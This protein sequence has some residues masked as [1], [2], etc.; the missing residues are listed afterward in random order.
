[1]WVD[2]ATLRA[3]LERLGVDV[4]AWADTELEDR[5]C[6]AE[7]AFKAETKREFDAADYDERYDGTDTDCLVLRHFPVIELYE[8]AY[9]GKISSA[10]SPVLDE[11][12]GLL[13]LQNG[14]VWKRGRRN[15]RVRYR[16]GYEV[17]PSDIHRATL[18]LAAMFVLTET[19][20]DFDR[21]GLKSFRVLNYREDYQ[22]PFARQF[23]EW[24]EE[25]KD[26]VERYRRTRL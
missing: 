21:K 10:V 20:S 12:R 11:E 2:V 9:M 15:I 24:R 16:A 22:G 18:L 6:L 1:M 14:S 7:L 8:V 17:I 13:L 26:I 23:E 25:V 3:F 19:A 5:I 4:S